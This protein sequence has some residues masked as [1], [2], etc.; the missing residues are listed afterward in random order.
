MKNIEF[1]KTDETPFRKVSDFAP[2][3]FVKTLS[4]TDAQTE[5]KKHF[6]G[7]DGKLALME[8]KE[9][10]DAES[11]LHYHDESEIFFVLEGDMYFGNRKCSE[12]DS[13][14]IAAGTQ[15]KFKTGPNGCRYLKFNAQA[16]RMVNVVHI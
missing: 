7:D 11:V 14:Y 10:S 3:D 15:Y 4:E 1:F 12:G 5:I 9:V 13:I 16:D 2:I 6:S 8:I